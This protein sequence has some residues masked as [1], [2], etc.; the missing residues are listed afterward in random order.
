MACSLGM[1]ARDQE[2]HA[3]VGKTWTGPSVR[4]RWSDAATSLDKK[5]NRGRALWVIAADW[6]W[7]AKGNGLLGVSCTTRAVC[8]L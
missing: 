6:S 1:D 2:T 8:R 3:R 4:V 7:E 5:G